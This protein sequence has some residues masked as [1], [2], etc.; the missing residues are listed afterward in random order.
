MDLYAV[1]GL[2]QRASLADIKRAYRRLARRYHPGINPGDRTAEVMFDRISEAYETLSDPVRRQQYDAAGGA[3]PRPAAGPVAFSGF[4]FSVAA[5]GAQAATFSELFAD[6]LHPVAPGDRGRP[7]PGADLHATL[8]VPFLDA[9]HGV[10]R[11]VVV[12]RHDVCGSCRGTGHVM[13][14]EGRCLH[15]QGTGALR[16]ARGH[17]VFSKPCSGCGG[18]GRQRHQ[19]CGVCAAQGRVVRSEAVPVTVPP[20]TADGT[21]IRIAEQ[22]HAG[23]HGGRTGDLYV[24]VHAAPHPLFRREG[25]DLHLEVPVAVHEA[26]LGA[27][28]DVPSLEGTVRLRIPPGT[29]SGHRFRLRQRGVPMASG[30]RGDLIV[31]TR[32]VLPA[33]VD[34]RSKEL[35]REFGRINGEDVRREWRTGGGASGT[36]AR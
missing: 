31:Q 8:K 30:G 17:M 5:R 32:L 25:D 3:A 33:T 16:W 15:C 35:I 21:R 4:D 9:M 20:G 28:I 24:T 10:Q 18:T 34:E 23:R 19:R 27:R 1:L 29:Q 22:G 26:V 13:T 11:H 2:D 36:E 6:V 12:T 7:E 14:A